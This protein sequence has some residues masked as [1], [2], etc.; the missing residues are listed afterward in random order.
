MADVRIERFDK[1]PFDE[2]YDLITVELNIY[3]NILTIRALMH[4]R[5][6]K[7]EFAEVVKDV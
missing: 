2:Y 7:I 6:E 1:L 3:G 4:H 5:I